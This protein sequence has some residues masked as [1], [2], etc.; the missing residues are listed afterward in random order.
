MKKPIM[1]GL[2]TM[3]IGYLCLT[4]VAQAPA[5]DLLAAA[6]AAAQ[7]YP[8]A[9]AV[10]LA[11]EETVQVDLDGTVHDTIHRTFLLLSQ[12]GLDIYG[13]AQVLY[14]PPD[15]EIKLDYARTILPDGREVALDTTAISDHQLGDWS[16]YGS[17]EVEEALPVHLYSIAM[18]NLEE[19][20]VVDWQVTVTGQYLHL[21]GKFSRVW[22][23]AAK[24][25]TVKLR[26]EVRVPRRMPFWWAVTGID[27]EPGVQTASD[28]V[29][30]TF[31]AHDITGIPQDEP[32]MP[33][34]SAL[35]PAVITSTIASWDEFAE[36]SAHEFDRSTRPDQVIIRKAKALTVD[37]T[38]KKMKIDR[39]YKFVAN[40]ISYSF[41]PHI[42]PFPAATT[43][44]VKRGDCKD[45][46]AL[47]IALLKAV[48]ITAYPVL[49]DADLGTDIDFNL[50]PAFDFLNHAII[51][52][53]DD[54]GWWFLDPSL[55]AGYLPQYLPV[56][57]TD[58]HAML[59]LG[60]P[61][62]PWVEVVTP[63]S[64]P[65][66]TEVKT[67]AD[68]NVYKDGNITIQASSKLTGAEA[69]GLQIFLDY[70]SE[71]DIQNY[72]Q[73]SVDKA[74]PGA[75]IVSFDPYDQFDPYAVPV[76]FAVTI[77]KDGAVDMTHDS[78]TLTVPY[79]PPISVFTTAL[80]DLDPAQRRYP[81]FTIPERIE[82]ST[83]IQLPRGW[84]AVLPAGV[85]V[86]NEI[87]S[88]SSSY[89]EEV[90][91]VSMFTAY[92]CD[93]VLQ[94]NVREIPPDKIVLLKEIFDALK[95]DESAKIMI[96]RESAS[97]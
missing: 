42:R 81:Y 57:D 23:L 78:F 16:D 1:F 97:N 6:R 77:R 51:A 20:A 70:Y 61:D 4:V 90:S 27:L 46:V 12:T 32:G 92:S 5:S 11:N 69:A 74:L 65:D 15:Q 10:Y 36:F 35:S 47:L 25:P 62:R 96:R 40:Q 13:I 68:M 67:S 34:V 9:D 89:R 19:G 30:Y 76:N 44:F 80:P 26:C 95:Q 3:M 87:G 39:I 88:F 18:P 29:T 60:E 2:V 73:Q 66:A 59:L 28:T 86:E 82:L 56:Q 45:Q 75:K 84:R 24:I 72:Y 37:C 17:G 8:D 14:V 31:C 63:S 53:P 94:I 21:P 48:G 93:R 49:L 50:P 54:N 7:K 38:S 64:T 58:K 43:F 55:G 83:Y 71:E 52:I 33:A 85:H 91:S 41:S 79:P 22:Y